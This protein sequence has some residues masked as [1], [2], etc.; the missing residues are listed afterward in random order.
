MRYK[1]N[2]IDH[3]DWWLVIMYVALMLIGWISIY[4]ALYQEGSSIFNFSEKYGRQFIWMVVAV[5]IAIIILLFN[6]KFFEGFAYI[7]YFISILSLIG[8]LIF[9]IEVNGAKSWFDF[10]FF[11]IQPAEFAKC[12]TAL[13]VAKYLSTLNINIEKMSTKL[14][15]SSIVFAP[16]LFVIFQNDTGSA[17]VYGSF[18]IVFY[19]F[20]FPANLLIISFIALVLFISSIL[21]SKLVL[22]I[23]IAT[24]GLLFFLA[25]KKKLKEIFITISLVALSIG[26]VSSVDYVFENVLEPHQVTRIKILLGQESDPHGAG[27]N[28]NQSMIAIGSGGFNGKGFLKGTQTK[29]NFVPEQ[30]TDFIFCTI[31]EEWGFLG[32]LFV[33]ALYLTFLIRLIYITERQ[34]SVFSKIYG[35]GVASILFFHIAVN[36]AMTIGLAPV[37][38]IPL[39]FISYG[40]SSLW[41]FTILLF[42]FINLDSYRLQVLR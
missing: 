9:G 5:F 7:L 27:Y 32:S 34:R 18:I 10:G 14:I 12:A 13:A 25:S 26:F 17:L 19:R 40:G 36:I 41:G 35:Y 23:I 39:P 2:I 8:V 38:G 29:F 20:G 42:I 33:L 6:W 15:V 16:V 21:I 11:R 37:I 24:I 22:S 4:A 1:K 3:I 30:S 28:V 31:G